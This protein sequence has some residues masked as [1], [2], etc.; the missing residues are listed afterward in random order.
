MTP[1]KSILKPSRTK[2]RLI[3]SRHTVRSID[4]ANLRHEVSSGREMGFGA[5]KSP[6]NRTRYSLSPCAA[7]TA[8]IASTDTKSDVSVAVSEERHCF[9]TDSATDQRL[10]S[11]E[12]APTSQPLKHGARGSDNQRRG[13]IAESDLAHRKFSANAISIL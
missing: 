6:A 3:A 2:K 8:E 1:I 7:Q 4:I 10:V 9:V 13:A 11:A 5:G 12:N